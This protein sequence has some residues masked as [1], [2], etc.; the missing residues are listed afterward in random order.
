MNTKKATAAEA[1]T[2]PVAA[3]PLSAKISKPAAKQPVDIKPEIVTKKAE[4]KMAAPVEA[5]EVKAVKVVKETKAAKKPKPKVVRDS[6]TMPQNEYQKIADIKEI[7]LKAGLQVK[8]SEVL[9]AGVIALCAMSE[10]Q[11]KVALSSLDKIKTG[12]PNKH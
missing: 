8:K 1:K 11:L 4:V 6:F 12:R 7:G 9:R 3:K 10:E 2:A 5:K